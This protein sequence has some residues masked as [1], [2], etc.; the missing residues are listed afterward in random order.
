MSSATAGLV[1]LIGPAGLG[2]SAVLMVFVGNPFSGVT[3]APELLPGGADHLGQWLPPGAGANLLRSTAYFDGHGA[4]GHLLV[5]ALW[6]IGGIAA[7]RRRPP[8]VAPVRRAPVP[9]A[10]TRGRAHGDGG[11][12]GAL[13]PA[14][15]AG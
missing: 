1:A 3:S 7:V 6:S 9:A 13:R 14:S 11:R 15:G 2:I 10:S 4:A 12:A 8:H 5:L